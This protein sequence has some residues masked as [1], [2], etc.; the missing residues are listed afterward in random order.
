M[1]ATCNPCGW[2]YDVKNPPD[3]VKPGTPF[4]ELPDDFVCPIC[5]AGKEEFT[6]N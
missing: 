1:N 4:N 2:V 3:G 6:V 5:G